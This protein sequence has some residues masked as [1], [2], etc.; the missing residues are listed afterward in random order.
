MRVSRGEGGVTLTE[1]LVAVVVLGIIIFPLANAVI[2]FIRLTDQASGQLKESH[3][4]QLATAYFAQDVESLGTRDWTAYPY[5]LRPSVE[6]GAPATGGLYP[7]GPA[8]LPAAVIRMAWDDPDTVSGTRV[9]RVAY[10]VMTVGA[11]RQLHRIVCA[12]PGPPVSEVVLA[13]DLDTVAPAVTCSTPCTGP[14]VPATIRLTL[15][16]RDPTNSSAAYTVD[17]RGQRSQT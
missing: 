11:Q 8:G 16:I 1:I 10:V 14:G 5:P 4:A 3:D 6:L 9:I 17:L 13:H 7:C 12:G 15:T 2:G